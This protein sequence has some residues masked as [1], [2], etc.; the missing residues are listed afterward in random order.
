ML[1]HKFSHSN[2]G[3]LFF[4]RLRTQVVCLQKFPQIQFR[5]KPL[6]FGAAR[7]IN[8]NA[9]IHNESNDCKCVCR[10]NNTPHE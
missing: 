8:I 10:V 1:H 7:F 3:S 6:P 2:D 5:S 9:T 4:A